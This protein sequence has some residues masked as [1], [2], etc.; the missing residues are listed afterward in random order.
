MNLSAHA[1]ALNFAPSSSTTCIVLSVK[2]DSGMSAQQTMLSLPLIKTKLISAL[3]T[4][5]LNTTFMFQESSCAA[6]MNGQPT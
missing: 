2:S 3:A 1:E 5:Y 6:K 4:L